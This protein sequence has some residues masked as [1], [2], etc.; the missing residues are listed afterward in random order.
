MKERR[1]MEWDERVENEIAIGVKEF[2]CGF[3]LK[4]LASTELGMWEMY[5]KLVVISE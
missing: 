5:L 3:L 4:L 2:K 1:K